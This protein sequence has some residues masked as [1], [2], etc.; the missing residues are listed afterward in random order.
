MPNDLF[1]SILLECLCEYPAAKNSFNANTINVVFVL[2]FQ[3]YN[4]SKHTTGRDQKELQILQNLPKCFVYLL[5]QP[6]PFDTRSKGR[7]MWVRNPFW[8]VSL[9]VMNVIETG[10][11]EQKKKKRNNP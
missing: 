4:K 9:I 11:G 1:I 2:S 10:G 5:T 7:Y 6:D 3:I 8:R